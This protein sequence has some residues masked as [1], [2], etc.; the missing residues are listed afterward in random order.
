MYSS[1][2]HSHC[3][4]SGTQAWTLHSHIQEKRH[5]HPEAENIETQAFDTDIQTHTQITFRRH[6]QVKVLSDN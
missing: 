5:R 1:S 6:T 4:H 3:P 2:H